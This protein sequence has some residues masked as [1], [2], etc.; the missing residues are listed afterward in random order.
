MMNVC[1]RLVCTAPR[2][3]GLLHKPRNYEPKV[4]LFFYFGL[5][6]KKQTA[7]SVPCSHNGTGWETKESGADSR[8]RQEIVFSTVQIGSGA[9]PASCS[10]VAGGYLRACEA[11]GVGNKANHFCH[12]VLMLRMV[13]A[14]HTLLHMPT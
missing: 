10:T 14:I 6:I 11:V 2:R 7:L 1:S 3:A 5:L 13:G 9:H 8:D 12:C 4:R